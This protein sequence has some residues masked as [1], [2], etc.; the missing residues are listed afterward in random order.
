MTQTVELVVLG[1]TKTGERSLVLHTLSREYGRRGFLVTVGKHTPM[2][3]FLPLNILEAEIVPNPKSA[4]W[5]ARGIQ[6]R[7]ALNGIR[8]NVRKNAVSLFLSEVLL[9]TLRDGMA[10]NGLYDWCVG[11]ILT[12]DGLSSDFANFHVRFLLELAAALGF[13]PTPEGIAPFAGED[14]RLLERFLSS[15]PGESLLI[16]MTGDVRT[17]ACR[18][19]LQYLEYHT[20]SPIRVRSLDI[21]SE[22]F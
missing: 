15:T 18:S 13:R 21:L 17:R 16:P 2:A 9:R 6:S 7:D 12:L 11:S 20:E 3:L 1:C 8:D 22:L 5:R 19:L 14:F 4:L 10:D